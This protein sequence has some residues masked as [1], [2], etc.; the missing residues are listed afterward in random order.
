LFAIPPAGTACLEAC[1]PTMTSTPSSVIILVAAFTADSALDSLSSR[2]SSTGYFFFPTVNPPAALT[3]SS[4][5]WAANFVPSPT[6]GI[7]PVSSALI[8]ILIGCA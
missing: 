7:S 4:H 3:S 1:G 5:I 2:T 8:P 6:L